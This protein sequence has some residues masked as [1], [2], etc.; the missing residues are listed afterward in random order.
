MEIVSHR[1]EL[2]FGDADEAC[3]R[4]CRVAQDASLTAE[5]QRFAEERGRFFSED[6][7]CAELRNHVRNSMT[8]AGAQKNLTV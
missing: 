3:E 4:I 2:M 8:T 7:F 5:L 6:R 1:E